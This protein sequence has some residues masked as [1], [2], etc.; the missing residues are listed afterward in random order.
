MLLNAA[1]LFHYLWPDLTGSGLQRSTTLEASTQNI[2]DLRCEILSI[3][4]Y[5]QNHLKCKRK[6]TNQRLTIDRG[7]V[8][9]VVGCSVDHNYCIVLFSLYISSWFSSLD[10]K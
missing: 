3:S 1:S 2:M 8:R 7:V 9:V 10:I 4:L 5:C 6:D